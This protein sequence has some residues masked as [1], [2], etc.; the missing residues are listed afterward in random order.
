[1]A[2][3]LK[4]P[5][6]TA[7]PDNCFVCRI[8]KFRW[9]SYLVLPSMHSLAPKKK[10][11]AWT[12]SVGYL[13]LKQKVNFLTS[14]IIPIQNCVMKILLLAPKGVPITVQKELNKRPAKTN[15]I[16]IKSRE[17]AARR[18]H[19]CTSFLSLQSTTQSIPNTSFMADV[20][21]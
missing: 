14:H 1:M 3:D 8:L 20:W 16:S 7:R 9:R 2:N 13:A 12:L 10:T 19:L 17:A 21:D 18:R 5:Y 6:L 15:H 11:V 4:Y